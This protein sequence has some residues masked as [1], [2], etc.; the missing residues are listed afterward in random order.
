MD[1]QLAHNACLSQID[2]GAATA[3]NTVATVQSVLNYRSCMAH[4][5]LVLTNGQ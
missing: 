3:G 5:G 1:Y 2:I 4:Y